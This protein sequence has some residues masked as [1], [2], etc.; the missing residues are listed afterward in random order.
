MQVA[1]CIV[2]GLC[3]CRTRMAI[4]C[5]SVSPTWEW[6]RSREQN[7]LVLSTG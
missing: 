5:T 2:I 1:N 7:A 4:R 3:R 6:W